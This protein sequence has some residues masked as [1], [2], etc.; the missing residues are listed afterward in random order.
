MGA[1][2]GAWGPAGRRGR[3]QTTHLRGCELHAVPSDLLALLQHAAR[4]LGSPKGQSLLAGGLLATGDECRAGRARPV[5]V[6]F[7]FGLAGP[8]RQDAVVPLHPRDRLPRLTMYN[9][10]LVLGH[11]ASGD[12]QA[13]EEAYSLI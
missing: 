2:A 13:R 5:V 12:L 3:G 9:N 11:C 10:V 1:C 7:H 8:D 6:N 4:Q